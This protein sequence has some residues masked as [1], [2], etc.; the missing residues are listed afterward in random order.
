[1]Q[2]V[3]KSIKEPRFYFSVYLISVMTLN[4][5][6]LEIVGEFLIFATIFSFFLSTLGAVSIKTSVN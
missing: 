2:L 5:F 1:M 3:L 4:Q 6:F